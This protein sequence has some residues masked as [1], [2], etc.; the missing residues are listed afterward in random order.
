MLLTR[1][2]ERHD[3]DLTCS[4]GI[5]SHHRSFADRVFHCLKVMGRVHGL[6]ERKLKNKLA[7]IQLFAFCLITN[8]SLNM[9]NY[10]TNSVNCHTFCT[11]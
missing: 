7:L 1:E 11:G 3:S 4:L 2:E 5:H 6:I 8:V 9:R 10:N